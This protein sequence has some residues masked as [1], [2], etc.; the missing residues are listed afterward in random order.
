MT[1]TFLPGRKRKRARHGGVAQVQDIQGTF[2]YPDGRVRYPDGMSVTDDLRELDEREAAGGRPLG[3]LVKPAPTFTPADPLRDTGQLEAVPE[4]VLEEVYHERRP[5]RP[6]RDAGDPLER[7]VPVPLCLEPVI[8]DTI[9]V[10]P[11]AVPGN[12]IAPYTGPGWARMLA[13]S[14]LGGNGRAERDRRR[15]EELRVQVDQGLGRAAASERTS[16]RHSRQTI[17][18]G[19]YRCM[20]ANYDHPELTG[21][22]LAMVEALNAAAQARNWRAA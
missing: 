22:L 10:P 16:N 9:P 2:R 13:A 6:Y 14:R 20:E 15:A 19:A 5:D 17:M 18:A 21:R 8:I 1:L 4:M 3:G 7:N 11:P 12:S